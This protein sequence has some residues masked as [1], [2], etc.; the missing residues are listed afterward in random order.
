[1]N[2]D[3]SRL[4]EIITGED[5]LNT[6]PAWSRDGWNRISFNRMNGKDHRPHCNDANGQ[7]G[8]E[9]RIGQRGWINPHLVDDRVFIQQHGGKSFL[10]FAKGGATMQYDVWTCPR[11]VDGGS[12]LTGRKK[13][14]SDDQDSPTS[15]ASFM[16]CSKSFGL[17]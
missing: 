14:S 13:A 7:P 10:L 5:S 4:Y 6:E 8:V 3:G 16:D 1:M 15:K 12:V 11:K 2:A 17:R 9:Q